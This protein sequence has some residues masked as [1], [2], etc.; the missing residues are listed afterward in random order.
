MIRPTFRSTGS[1]SF[2]GSINVDFDTS[3]STA[4]LSFSPI[5]TAVWDAATWDSGI[6]GGGLNIL[7]N[8]QGVNGVGEYAAPQLQ[9][10]SQG[11]DVRWVSTVVVF[12][13]GNIL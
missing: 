12:E 1:P 2:L 11:I 3:E 5:S 8:W 6:W 10:A 4:P 9:L 7:R 13:N